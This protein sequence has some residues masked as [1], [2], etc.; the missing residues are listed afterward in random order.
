MKFSYTQIPDVPRQ[1]RLGHLNAITLKNSGK[2]FLAGDLPFSDHLPNDSVSFNLALHPINIQNFAKIC[3][4]FH[5]IFIRRIFFQ[6][7]VFILFL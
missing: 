7:D 6:S 1:G 5:K 3:I 4:N 2:L